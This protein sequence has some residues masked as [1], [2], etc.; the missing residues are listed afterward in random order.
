[1]SQRSKERKSTRAEGNSFC[2]SLEQKLCSPEPYEYFMNFNKKDWIILAG[3]ALV[4]VLFVVGGHGLADGKLHVYF[5][6]IGQGDAIFVKTGSGLQILID[7]GPDDTVLRRLGEVMPFYDRSI[8][9]VVATHP[10]TDHL[11]GLVSVLEKYKVDQILETG[12]ACV[13]SLCRGWEEAKEKEDTRV[14][15]AYLGQEVEV[16]EETSFLVLHPF[17]SQEGK[18]L[19]KRNNGGIV[20]KLL[21]GSQSVL[22]TADIEKQIENKLVLAGLDLEAD[23]LKVAHHGSKTST[24]ENFLKAVSPL[25]A[26]IEVGA[27]NRYGHPTDEVLSRLENFGIKYY[28]TDTEGTIELVLDG[29]NY[30]IK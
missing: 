16:D 20:L 2:E 13:T 26:F 21:Y 27:H 22:L 14:T 17:E 8:D 19:S 1:L 12:M 10:D 7:G 23:F 5:L 3:L 29:K 18:V 28:R 9:L 4:A 6:D 30:Q 25:A 15:L 24:T 11:A